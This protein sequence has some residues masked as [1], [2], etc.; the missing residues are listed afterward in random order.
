MGRSVEVPITGEVLGWA[1]REGGFTATSFGDRVGATADTV[2]AWIAESERPSKTQFNAIVHVLRRPSA[3]FFLPEPPTQASVPPTFRKAP[4]S[5]NVTPHELIEIRWALGLQELAAELLIEEEREPVEFPAARP[6]ENPSSAADR[7]R[8]SLG[9]PGNVPRKWKDSSDAFNTL[10][11]QLESAGVL[12][13][14]LQLK[15][16]GQQ[17][18]GIRGFSAWND[19]APLLVVNTGYNPAAKMY[20]LVH[21]LGHLMSR[22]DSSCLAYSGPGSAKEPGSER[23]CEL[24]AAALLLPESRVD[25][26]MAGLG[27]ARDGELADANEV[28]RIA[29]KMH[30]SVRAM[31][32]RLIDL[33]YSP[34]GLYGVIDRDF[35]TS[36][37]K[38]GQSFGPTRDRVAR[39]IAETGP[40]LGQIMVDGVRRR[41]LSL[42]ES[43]SYLRVHPSE[44]RTLERRLAS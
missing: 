30:V 42:R 23:W 33:G 41:S 25:E 13:F 2:R 22:S 27:Y 39:R 15:E 21:E 32:L 28:A 6:N 26:Y 36:D 38:G 35:Q 10:K 4:G 37:R 43:A 34:K 29:G 20:S 40:R 7:L 24:F 12:V 5:R 16:R 17:E 9:I 44:M 19:Y 14:Q 1:I 11:K 3:M 18:P 8:M 31:A